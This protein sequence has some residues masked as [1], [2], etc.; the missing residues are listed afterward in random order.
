M[1]EVLM[2]KGAGKLIDMCAGV[3]RGENVS[4]ITDMLTLNVAKV[5][6]KAAVGKDANEVTIFIMEPRRAHGIEPPESIAAA[7][8]NSDVVF[9]PTSKSIAHTK[10]TQRAREDGVRIVTIAEVTDDMLISGGI[11]ANFKEQAAVTQRIANMLTEAKKAELSTKKGTSL[12]LN[13]E[14]RKGRAVTGLATQPGEYA[15]PPNIEASIAPVEEDTNGVIIVDGSISGIG[16]VTSPVKITFE[17]GRAVKIEGGREA[18]ELKSTLAS[19][20][21]PNVYFAA[22]LGLGLNPFCTLRGLLLEDEGTFGSAHIALGS[23]ADFGGKLRTPVHI[24]NIMCSA[25]V[26]LDGI[27]VFENGKLKNVET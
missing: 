15:S 19:T 9:I 8:K 10:A 18:D 5:L 11:Q 25:T 24:D 7:M 27:L 2:M 12:S 23:N 16:V 4:I 6:A 26:K 3:K 20:S 17:K 22:E 21:D 14:G 1:K 13:L